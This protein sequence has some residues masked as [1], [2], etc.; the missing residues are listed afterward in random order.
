MNLSKKLKLLIGSFAEHLY[1]FES[2]KLEMVILEPEH[3]L[4]SVLESHRAARK[5]FFQHPRFAG[6]PSLHKKEMCNYQLKLLAPLRGHWVHFR[7]FVYEGF[8]IAL[9]VK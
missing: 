7:L 5:I 6:C 3:F 9:L 2:K 1:L 8:K 4:P